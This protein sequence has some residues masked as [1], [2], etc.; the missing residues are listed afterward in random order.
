MNDFTDQS[1]SVRELQKYLYFISLYDPEIPK[2]VPDG[3]YGAMTRDAV[4]AFQKKTGLPVTGIVD[5]ITWDAIFK[6]YSEISAS[7]CEPE[8]LYIFPSSDYVVR[9]GEKS[10]IVSVIQILLRCLNGEY[11][12]KV[13]ITVSG[14]YTDR[15]ARAVKAVQRIHGL[16]ETGLVDV[17]T[18]NAIANDYR[19]FCK[20]CE[21]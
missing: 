7:C 11:S 6:A 3:I 18:W 10:D 16:E 19:V 17:L 13:V 5:K 1:S 8:P 12:F 15:D 4:S 2:V 14:L 21:C 9:V 20:N